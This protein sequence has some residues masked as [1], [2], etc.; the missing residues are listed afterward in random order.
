MPISIEDVRADIVPDS[1]QAQ[2]ARETP[3]GR[4]LDMDKVVRELRRAN[5]RHARLMAD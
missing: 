5:E 3:S 2:T 4:P 1:G